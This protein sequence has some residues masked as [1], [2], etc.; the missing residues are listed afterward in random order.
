[1]ATPLSRLDALLGPVLPEPDYPAIRARLE[2]ELSPAQWADVQALILEE[3]S[4][5]AAS[6]WDEMHRIIEGIA[7]HFGPF[8]PAI[9][10]V[11]YHVRPELT[12]YQCKDGC[13]HPWP[14]CGPV[15]DQAVELEAGAALEE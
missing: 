2:A 8:A 3:E 6:C 7:V 5:T 1:M 4:T 10:A 9:R 12:S 14:L 11:A 13:G 15:G